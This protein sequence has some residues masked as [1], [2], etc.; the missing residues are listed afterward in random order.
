[1]GNF[2]PPTDGIVEEK[3]SFVP[4]S[5][6][7][8]TEDVKKKA[9]SDFSEPIPEGGIGA[10]LL[11]PS[12]SESNTS[13][14]SESGST[15]ETSN[16]P[17]KYQWSDSQAIKTASIAPHP[18]PEQSKLQTINSHTSEVAIQNP[19]LYVSSPNAKANREQYI[20]SLN[21]PKEDQAKALADFDK[22]AESLNGM[23]VTFDEIKKDPNNPEL[24]IKLVDGMI[25][26]NKP[27][28][29]Q[30]KAD[31]II[32]KFPDYSPAYNYKASIE[33]KKGNYAFATD[34]L[35]KGIEANPSDAS[36]L[37]NRAAI[38]TQAGDTQGAIQDL[39]AATS[40]TKN[41]YLLE[42]IWTQ[43]ATIFNK[44]MQDKSLAQKY[45]DIIKENDTQHDG[46][47]QE[48]FNEK[49]IEAF[50]EANKYATLNNEEK[51]T[52][53]YQWNSTDKKL[54]VA[55]PEIKTGEAVTT[56][57]LQPS[58]SGGNDQ[59]KIQAQAE[60][61]NKIVNP[62]K[63][64]TN[65]VLE[66]T[67][68]HG[69]QVVEGVKQFAKGAVPELEQDLF[70]RTKI[71][72]AHQALDMLLG[73]ANAAMGAAS[74][75]APE[76][77]AFN[78]GAELAPEDLSKWAFSP[79]ASI[80]EKAG[81]KPVEGSITAK[82]LKTADL[83]LTLAAFHKLSKG[84]EIEGLEATESKLKNGQELSKEDARPIADLLNEQATPDNL[85]KAIGSIVKGA[86]ESFEKI[87]YEPATDIEL[88]KVKAEQLKQNLTEKR[89]EL[90]TTIDKIGT[91]AMVKGMAENKIPVT[92]AGVE[93]YFHQLE[94]GEIGVAKEKHQEVV[95][96]SESPV[97]ET[98]IQ[99]DS[100]IEMKVE[101]GVKKLVQPTKA[102]KF[103]PMSFEEL[104]EVKV[105]DDVYFK[106]KRG[107]TA[108]RI[109][110]V[111]KQPDGTRRV[112]FEGREGFT[113]SLNDL[114]K[115]EEPKL[116]TESK[117][118]S[119]V[120]PKET[121][122]FANEIIDEGWFKSSG[123]LM[124]SSPD[125]GLPTKGI[126]QGIL[127]IKAGKNSAPAKHLIEALRKAKETGEM[128]MV[129]GTGGL[130]VRSG[131]NIAELRK[132]NV[133]IP[134]EINEAQK[135]EA[136][137]LKIDTTIEA[138]GIT[139]ENFDNFV[140]E[141]DW[142]YTPEEVQRIK[143]HIYGEEIKTGDIP[144]SSSVESKG[145]E[146]GE[147]T[148]IK[149]STGSE[150][151][152]RTE[153]V[154]VPTK[155]EI[156]KKKL[157]DARAA[158][159]KA[160]G[161]SS[162]G[163]ESLP[164][165]VA[166]VKAAI[167]HGYNSAKDFIRDFKEDFISYTESEVESAFN[168]INKKDVSESELSGIKKA[169]VPEEKISQAEI[170]KRSVEQVLDKGKEV[171]DS[172]EID[173][174]FLTSE[175]ANGNA[176]A[177]QPNEVAAL[178]Y[179]KAK[180]DNNL[181]V[182]YKEVSEASTKQDIEAQFSAQ[183]KVAQLEKQLNDYHVMSVKTAYEQS[184]AF[185]L[186]KM[187]LDSE[188]N[189]Q[190][191]IA[192]YKAENNGVI[193]AEVE[194]KFREYAIELSEANDR[195]KEAEEKL[196]KTE[197]ELT[198]KN[199]K[200]ANDRNI[201]DVRHDQRIK[202]VSKRIAAKIR[203]GK[204]HRPNVFSSASPASLVWDG[205]LEIVAR[206]V[207]AGGTIAQA[208]ANGISHIKASAWYKSL[209]DKTKAQAEE[210]YNDYI[211]N[212]GKE[213][214][215]TTGKL[216]IPQSVIR[217]FVERG[218]DNIDELV[219]VVKDSIKEE[220]PNATEREVRDAITG[221]GKTINLS[222]DEI[223]VQ[224][225]KM[226]RIGKLVSGIEDAQNKQRP[227]RSGLQ[228][229]RLTREEME[230][231]RELKGLLKD[232]PF[233][234]SNMEFK[235]KSGLDSMKARISG[236]ISELEK[237]IADKDFSTKPIKKP[238]R[239]DDEVIQAKANLDKVKE[240][241]DLEQEKNKLQ[242]Q[243]LY[244]KI[245]DVSKDLALGIGKTLQASADMSAPFR[246][247]LIN[248]ARPS[249]LKLTAQEFK[250]MFQHAF[251]ESKAENWLHYIK[252][253]PEYPLMKQAGLFLSEPNAKLSAREEI[254]KS[255]LVQKIPVIGHILK[256]SERAYSG[257][258]NMQRVNEFMKVAEKFKRDGIDP[259]TKEGAEVFKAWGNYVNNATGRG[260]MGSFEMAAN[261]L[262]DVFFSPRLIAARFNVLNPAFYAKM[263]KAA[264]LEALKSTAEFIGV[265][266]T[267]LTLAKIGGA[268]VET[269]PRSSDFGKVKIG[270]TRL[271]IWGGFV[272]WVRLFGQ[273]AT[274]ERKSTSTSKIT[275][276]G[277][278]YGS[279]TRFDLLVSFFKNKLA[280]T[281][282]LAVRMAESHLEKKDG[283]EKRVSAYGE[284]INYTDE[285][286]GQALPL[287]LQDFK[288]LAK[289]HD[290][291]TLTGLMLASFFGFGVQQYK[292]K[293][294]TSKN[295]G[296]KHV[297][298]K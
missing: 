189:L 161:L 119:E 240:K 138:E 228:R 208:T 135:L 238:I 28:E 53:V 174:Q 268:N 190:T 256:A 17:Y 264:R 118:L 115:K 83:I 69:E 34:I 211:K 120:Y 221:Y 123:N 81:Y 26:L 210:G 71:T 76:M 47:D 44:L 156:S 38:K 262:S 176:K 196:K 183:A 141:N 243:P 60:L 105:G 173:P 168:A 244:K 164:E 297:V 64:L 149:E 254:Y 107:V 274:G 179:Y 170:E 126:E 257:F 281:P 150:E 59:L 152:T 75:V 16:K 129:R 186:R 295:D 147:L 121:I 160:G 2:V 99:E 154:K 1:M 131:A 109:K 172:G 250:T 163:L 58:E 227:L 285:A 298:N 62:D 128:P 151:P 101:P 162:G 286:I 3:Q 206:S 169:L 245:W 30:K 70:K 226:K 31:E 132:S 137:N 275:E 10:P 219:V 195:L 63:P 218:I 93:H 5:D 282:A 246:Q 88:Q 57:V 278:D 291:T 248:T 94:N 18:E 255:N 11:Q 7:I 276:L 116:N 35:D 290:P 130:V 146:L 167:E 9:S 68:E 207:E 185:R 125:L 222:K 198:I 37:N 4:P 143:Q 292:P 45:I 233:E 287:Y 269:D 220:Y 85:N 73:S 263:P 145:A 50:K 188:Y 84:K 148:K 24:Q 200:E 180:L 103:S 184:L 66:Y 249:R 193:P 74:L 202:E 293:K 25:A 139:K 67:K 232:L 52:P 288:D 127:D 171:V 27:E 36:L 203:E 97:E 182:A 261:S 258:L 78:V 108:E 235:Q 56:N 87:K 224:I 234:E 40:I 49:Y 158:F 12:L 205:A 90:K 114:V 230:M 242:Q 214:E 43:K 23:K 280:P 8:V 92:A 6:A 241:Y 157:D 82:G 289:E 140:K 165:F 98:K 273:L 22:Y 159:R 77:V 14:V 79:I 20:S 55:P 223:N 104:K 283:E 134:K 65:Y 80:I 29:A 229:D 253:T 177:L 117:I 270:D 144:T 19:N 133:E 33:A 225:R 41:P 265:G 54:E 192:K 217:D 61:T 100:P 247:G 51:K 95:A 13:S 199:I 252:S 197:E 194:A 46:T 201:K 112:M 42:N 215:V 32:A 102:D 110:E 259:T 191:Q 111:I 277:N 122:D 175:I 213:P 284:D 155:T 153:E 106:G 209:D 39:D 187:L 91:D 271:D 279:D 96:R 178:V 48:F 142:I 296:E 113:P 21:I 260:S 72:P 236:R 294:D 86:P 237:R 89:P 166:V 231:Q 216:K 204:L 181:S 267:A 239:L 212:Y 272:Q 136:E 15:S 251:S 266:L 124:E